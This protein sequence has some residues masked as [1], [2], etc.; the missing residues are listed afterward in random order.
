MNEYRILSSERLGEKATLI[1]HASGLDIYVIEKKFSTTYALFGTKYGS[2]DNRFRVGG[3]GEFV[4]VPDGI[5]HYLEHKMFENENGTDAFEEFAVTGANANAYTSFLHTM[6]LFSCT[7]R[8]EEN[9]EILLNFV[10]HPYFTKETV[11]KEKGIIGQEIRMYEDTPGNALYFS[12]MR[13]LYENHPVRTE[14]AGSVRSIA[15]ITEKTLYDCYG[16]FYNLHN[17]ALCVSGD[18]TPGTVERIA[19]KVLK[20][21]PPL[22]LERP[23]L[24]EKPGVYKTRETKEMQVSQ[25]MLAIGVKDVAISENP[26]ER[27]RKQIVMDLLCDTLFSLSA[28]FPND[29]YESGLI[30]SPL[31]A[32]AEHNRS[33]SCFTFS[34]ESDEPETVF[35][36]IRDYIEEM[37]KTGVDP[38]IFESKK[39]AMYGSAV[40][41][42]DSSEE[43]ANTFLSDVFDG[44]T[45]FDYVDMIG[46]V[47]VDEVN[48][49]LKTMFEDSYF[50][51]AVVNPPADGK[52]RQKGNAK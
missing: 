35:K 51:M 32:E 10:T 49:A 31:T 21:A 37:K 36:K 28:P 4:T 34:A 22:I 30:S 33:F 2:V 14:I 39:R 27:L 15:K 47:T 29:L 25:P 12:L 11:E 43:I 7:D 5:A 9:L 42:F 13:C 8:F 6:Y 38:V 19:D 24:K 18:V 3:T 23:A 1:K 20:K 16:T 50:A 41:I 17:M 52:K 44:V 48:E 40:R 26:L 45:T 46:C